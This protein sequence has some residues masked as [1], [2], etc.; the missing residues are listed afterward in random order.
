MPVIDCTIARFPDEVRPCEFIAAVR[1]DVM[2]RIGSM[3]LAGIPETDPTM[4]RSIR[5]GRR[6]H[7]RMLRRL[8]ESI[9]R[10]HSRH[11]T[12]PVPA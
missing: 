8:S 1:R 4:A 7:D 3:T 5:V 12:C 11:P 10:D 6:L 9:A 2:A